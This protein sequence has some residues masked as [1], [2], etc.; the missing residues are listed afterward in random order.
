MLFNRWAF[1][2]IGRAPSC[3]VS[4]FRGA[5]QS[6]GQP[7]LKHLHIHDRDRLK[8][9]NN[10][11]VSFVSTR[12]KLHWWTRIWTGVSALK[13]ASC[14]FIYW[15]VWLCLAFILITKAA[16]VTPLWFFAGRLVA[17]LITDFLQV[18]NLDFTLAVFQPEIN[19]VFCCPWLLVGTCE[20][21]VCAEGIE[22][23]SLQKT[24]NPFFLYF[25]SRFLSSNDVGNLIRITCLFISTVSSWFI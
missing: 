19:T 21:L 7:K 25:L 4:G 14:L 1:L 10:R 11:H 8:S 5:G 12:T 16:S 17:S 9:L 22:C 24:L 13:M 20:W 23:D 6:G 2:F 15:L 3:C 18:F